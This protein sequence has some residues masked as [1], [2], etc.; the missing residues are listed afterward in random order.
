MPQGGETPGFERSPQVPERSIETPVEG[1]DFEAPA[2]PA[3]EQPD[4]P[5]A[6]ASVPATA[7]V[8]APVRKDQA[9]KDVEHVLEEGLEETYRKMTSQ[10][11]EKF[12][13]EGERAAGALAEMVRRAKVRARE[14]LDLITRWLRGIPG[15]N[16]FYLAQ[17]AKLKTDKIIAL[18]EE[19]KKKRGA[20]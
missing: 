20:L 15:V 12:R 9:M 10:Q 18:A 2:A 7:P 5:A 1:A 8:E 3:V 17:E 6:A 16:S 11:Q 19:E 4:A 14:A 13:R